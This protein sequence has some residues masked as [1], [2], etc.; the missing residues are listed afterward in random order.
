MATAPDREAVR[1]E[2][3]AAGVA[4]DVHYPVPDHRQLFPTD[5][6]AA[7]SLPATEAASASVFSV[8]LFPELTDAEVERVSSALAGLD[9]SRG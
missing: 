4:T 5:R 1:A 3:R 2:L 6:P 9:S 7:V 8:P